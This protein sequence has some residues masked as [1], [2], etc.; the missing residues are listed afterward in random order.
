MSIPPSTLPDNA[1]AVESQL[2]QPK[3]VAP[4]SACGSMRVSAPLRRLM[5]VGACALGFA[6]VASLMEPL[7]AG[8]TPKVEEPAR[9]LGQL[10]GRNHRLKVTMGPLGPSYT[11][12]SRDGTVLDSDGDLT[13]LSRRHPSL[14]LN[15]GVAEQQPAVRLLM[16]AEEREEF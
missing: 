12:T 15:G 9:P 10:V 2:E 1:P 7:G 6:T 8:A 4:G 11:L 13:A 5:V 16:M 14:H 3:D